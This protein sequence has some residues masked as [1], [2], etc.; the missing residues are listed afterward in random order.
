MVRSLAQSEAEEKSHFCHRVERA[1]G[2]GRD[3]HQVQAARNLPGDGGRGQRESIGGIR[4]RAEQEQARLGE[5]EGR[6]GRPRA[7]RPAVRTTMRQSS[8]L[9]CHGGLRRFHRLGITTSESWGASEFNRKPI[10]SG[11]TSWEESRTMRNP[12][13]RGRPQ[14]KIRLLR[15]DVH[16]GCLSQLPITVESDTLT[17]N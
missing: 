12:K 8:S 6:L 15:T 13:W 16:F 7:T 9:S 2:H 3:R 17:E 11:R 5:A 10:L 4:D 1:D 14:A